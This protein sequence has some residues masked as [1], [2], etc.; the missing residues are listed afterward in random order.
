MRRVAEL[1]FSGRHGVPIGR[2]AIGRP[3]GYGL[4]AMGERRGNPYPISIIHY[5]KRGRG[6]E[7]LKARDKKITRMISLFFC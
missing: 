7:R 4:L 3:A 2:F 5:P 6:G 1:Q